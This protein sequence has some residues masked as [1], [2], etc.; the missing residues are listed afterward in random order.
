MEGFGGMGAVAGFVDVLVFAARS[1]G[2]P[3]E[4][5]EG[6]LIAALHSSVDKG[7]WGS[8]V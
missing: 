5:V 2:S 1:K 3:E 7:K 8:R 4:E 6:L